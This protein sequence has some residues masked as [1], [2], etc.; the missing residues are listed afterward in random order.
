MKNINLRNTTSILAHSIKTYIKSIVHLLLIELCYSLTRG[1]KRR[2]LERH[3][4]KSV[5]GCYYEK[6]LNI[7]EKKKYFRKMIKSFFLYLFKKKR[8]RNQGQ[9]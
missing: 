6:S 8:K 1:A 3:E 2:D 4:R 7:I 5:H 9:Y